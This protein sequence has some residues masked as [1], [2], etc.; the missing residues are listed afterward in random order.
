MDLLAV[1]PARAPDLRAQDMIEQLKTVHSTTQQRLS[2]ANSNYKTHADTRC[3]SLEFEVGDLVLAI[4]TKDRFPAR[5]YNKLSARKIGPVEILEKI[6]PNAYRLKLPS[7][8]HTSDVFNVKHLVPFVGENS[9]GDE[10][11]HDLRT[12]HFSPGEDDGDKI[13]N[14]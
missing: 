13:A 9:R 2:A 1:P 4:L 14:V 11:P 7:H 12:N 5:E 8:L 6:N 10:T 3:R